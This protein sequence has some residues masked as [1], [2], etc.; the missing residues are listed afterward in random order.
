MWPKPMLLLNHLGRLTSRDNQISSSSHLPDEDTLVVM[1]LPKAAV[2]LVRHSEDMRC[3]L[4][5][6]VLAV[7]LHGGAVVQSRDALVRVHRGNYRTNVGLQA[8]S[9]PELLLHTGW[10]RLTLFP[11][12]RQQIHICKSLAILWIKVASIFPCFLPFNKSNRRTKVVS[13]SVMFSCLPHLQHRASQL[14]ESL[15]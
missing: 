6:V 7:S 4:S 15:P 10:N 1:A 8:Q 5:H 12:E 11:N 13:A 14:Y 2:A 3:N 9:P